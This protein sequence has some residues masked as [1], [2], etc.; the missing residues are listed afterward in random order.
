MASVTARSR[1][2]LL[3][4]AMLALVVAGSAVAVIA[5][6]ATEGTDTPRRAPG[7][8][9]LPR[10][11]VASGGSSWRIRP[12]QIL[13]TGE[14]TGRLEGLKGS[15]LVHPGAL[16][17]TSWTATQAMGSGAVWID[18]LGR[19]TA[20]PVQVRAFRPV[21]GHFTRLTLRYSY[22]GKRYIDRR[23]LWRTG[24]LRTHSSGATAPSATRRHAGLGPCSGMTPSRFAL[25]LVA[26]KRATVAFDASNLGQAG[27]L[28]HTL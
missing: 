27:P 15:G 4:A 9:K 25:G 3:L 19:V 14:G 20:R 7:A 6:G 5:T 2:R 1:R 22:H 17:W 8:S 13:Y 26:G 11:L 23:R 21:R 18:E 24:V 28:G 16:K 12:A 10:L